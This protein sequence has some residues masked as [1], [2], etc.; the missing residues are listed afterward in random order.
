MLCEG[1]ESDFSGMP[2]L[3]NTLEHSYSPLCFDLIL[4]SLLI[5]I[6]EY[7]KN[8]FFGLNPFL[9]AVQ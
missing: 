8:M 9:L 4:F 5:F 3:S 7:L 2:L 1:D 6:F